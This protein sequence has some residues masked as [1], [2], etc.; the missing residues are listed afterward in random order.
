MT[1]LTDWQI[2]WKQ[3]IATA[4]TP[5]LI[6]TLPV[7]PRTTNGHRNSIRRNLLM[8]D[9][10]PAGRN[11]DEIPH[12]SYDEN[13]LAFPFS[14]S[15]FVF[16][17]LKI[18]TKMENVFHCSFSLFPFPRNPKM[19]KEQGKR[20]LFPEKLNT[21]KENGNR[22]GSGKTVNAKCSVVFVSG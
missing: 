22:E 16:R 19:Q 17:E 18:K 10:Q 15:V 3:L 2:P 12:R 7:M 14:L 9:G 5:K 4:A 20:F 6:Y 8:T 21:E 1:Y 11:N 13:I